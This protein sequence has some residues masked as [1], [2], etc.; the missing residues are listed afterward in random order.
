MVK[1]KNTILGWDEVA[2]NQGFWQIAQI[3]DFGHPELLETIVFILLLSLLYFS[4]F[5]LYLFV[6]NIFA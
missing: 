1:Y 6:F 5:F 3:L 2:P 4:T